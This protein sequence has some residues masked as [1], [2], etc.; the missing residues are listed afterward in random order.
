MNRVANPVCLIAPLVKNLRKLSLSGGGEDSS[1]SNGTENGTMG[2]TDRL[3]NL[4]LPWGLMH[5]HIPSSSKMDIEEFIVSPRCTT[6]NLSKSTFHSD[7][8]LEHYDTIDPAVYDTL[9]G[10]VKT[11]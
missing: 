1:S 9:F 5:V 2:G 8:A 4:G 11:K 10:M 7:F 6:G 3:D